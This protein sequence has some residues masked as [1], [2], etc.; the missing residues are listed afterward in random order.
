MAKPPT[1]QEQQHPQYKKDRETVNI[2]LAVKATPSDRDLVELAR[3][4]IRYHGF[5]GAK[6]IQ[7]DLDKLLEQWQ[8]TEDE[9]FAQTRKIH[10]IA[11]VYRSRPE[12]QEDWI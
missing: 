10:E 5:P 11:H 12:D 9:L 6:D 1:P 4:R 7:N 8:L 2:L 3:L